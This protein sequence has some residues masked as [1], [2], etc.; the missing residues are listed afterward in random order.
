[1]D[2]TALRDI[3]MAQ[4]EADWHAST[5]RQERFQVHK[6]TQTIELIFDRN[7]PKETPTKHKKYFS[8][9][10]DALLAPMIDQMSGRY[11]ESGHL[12]R[13]IL[14]RL[15]PKGTINAHSD[16]G[17]M[18]A[19]AHRIHLPIETNDKVVFM[20]GGEAMCMK[21]GEMWEINN[22]REHFVDN[23]G[24]QNRIHLIMDWAPLDIT[25]RIA[26]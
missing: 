21:P 18:F 22:L 3:V 24:E 16:I 1:V 4:T 15:S 20:V 26:T 9:G 5:W 25:R 11:S 12:I 19:N 14:A 8:L 6:F 13:A 17:P 2:I 7:L 10:C 23:G